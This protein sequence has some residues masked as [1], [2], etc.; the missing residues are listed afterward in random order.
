MSEA[1]KKEFDK[2]NKGPTFYLLLM[3][4][5]GILSIV[6]CSLIICGRKSL[7]RAIDVIDASADFIA[8]NKRVIAVPILH[9][10]ITLLVVIVWFGAYICVAS[11]NKIQPSSL[12]PQVK[13]LVWTK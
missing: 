6:F 13:D 4:T 11:L 12:S 8:H 9:F 1:E 5:F 10:F 3:I 2:D 7:Q